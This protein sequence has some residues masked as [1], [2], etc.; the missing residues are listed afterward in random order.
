MLLLMLGFYVTGEAITEFDKFSHPNWLYC[1][2]SY[3]VMM[4]VPFAVFWA[5]FK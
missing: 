2:G 3:A 5:V 4:S 1:P